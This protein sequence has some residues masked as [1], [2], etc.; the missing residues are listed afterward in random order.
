L[1]ISLNF[2]FTVLTH[3]LE[4]ASQHQCQC[5]VLSFPHAN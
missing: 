2:V 4:F 5:P 1:K 3:K